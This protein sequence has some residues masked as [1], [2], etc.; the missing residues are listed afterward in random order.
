MSDFGGRRARGS[1]DDRFGLSVGE[2]S[3]NGGRI[4]KRDGGSTELCLG[5]DDLAGVAEGI[6]GSGGGH[7]A[8]VW[9]CCR[10]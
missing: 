7:V 10:R 4:H 6:D 3:G 2:M 8:V 9:K 5:R 1:G